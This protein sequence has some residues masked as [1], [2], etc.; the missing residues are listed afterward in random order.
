[1][2]SLMGSRSGGPRHWSERCVH[3]A[4]RDISVVVSTRGWDECNAA[5]PVCMNP[6]TFITVR[7]VPTSVAD[8]WSLSALSRGTCGSRESLLI[9][10][11]QWDPLQAL[12][13]VRFAACKITVRTWT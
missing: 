3:R 8:L 9:E 7:D 2:R 13:I 5:N 12:V 6:R 11:P 4:L 1:M 10:E